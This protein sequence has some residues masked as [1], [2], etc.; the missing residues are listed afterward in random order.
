MSASPD[1][2]YERFVAASPQG[3]IFSTPWWLNAVAPGAFQVL[4]AE[5]DGEIQAAWPIVPQS[6][7]APGRFIV[8]PSLTP[9]LGILYGPPGEEKRQTRLGRER[10]L[11]DQLVAQLPACRMVR[12]AFHRSYGYWTPLSWAGFT[13][14][15]R[16]TFVLEPLEE[17]AV[18]K[19]LGESV[20]RQ[21]R[22]AEKEGVAVEATDDLDAFWSVHAQTF[23]R[24]GLGVPYDLELVR[25]I[26]AACAP[27]A[28][29]R[30]LLARDRQGRVHAGVYL[31]WDARSAYY[32][33]GGADHQL[34]S[35][36]AMSLAMWEAIRF[37]AGVSNAFDFEGSMLQPVERFVR[38]FGALPHPYS[39]VTRFA[40]PMWRLAYELRAAG[41][42]L[43]PL[44][45]P[46]RPPDV[47]G[48]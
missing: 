16:Y 12:A 4:L 11:T 41:R 9:W 8:Q 31:V 43:L 10:Q 38:A 39:V 20:R 17:A 29:R 27:R 1:D 32:L 28:V 25:R 15:T 45:S 18:W 47:A 3:T 34:R 33:M 42:R 40:S 13:Q 48:D 44:S 21:V 36:G 26:D 23:R 30:I 6:R 46:S 22:K 37:A 35:S 24:Q 7:G 2:R 19:G 5:L 14:T